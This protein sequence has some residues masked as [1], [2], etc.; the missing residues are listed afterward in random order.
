MVQVSELSHKLGT[1]EGNGKSLEEE[2]ARLQSQNLQLS[3]AKAEREVDASET[4]AKLHSAEEKVSLQLAPAGS[5]SSRTEG[6]SADLP[7]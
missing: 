7:D 3:K 2:L 5:S 1:T 6:P 4:R